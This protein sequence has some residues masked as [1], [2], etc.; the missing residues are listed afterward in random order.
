MKK[1]LLGFLFGISLAV[2]LAFKSSN[3]EPSPA[4]AEVNKVE[5]YYI[6]T[7]SKPV[8][9]YDSIGAFEIGFILDIQYE[10][11]RSNFIKKAKN[12]FPNADGLILNLNKKGLDKCVVIK[13]K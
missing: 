2:L 3:F 5:G 12:K 4:T 13:M 8:M 10:S 6:F 7:D 9:P 1:Y 11:I